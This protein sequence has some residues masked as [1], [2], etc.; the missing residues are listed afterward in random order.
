[1]RRLIPLTIVLALCAAVSCDQQ[2]V[3]PPTDGAAAVPLFAPKSN[4]HKFVGEWDFTFPV[5][6]SGG[7]ILEWH[8]WGWGQFMP[9]KSPNNVEVAVF[10]IHHLYTNSTGDTFHYLDVGPDHTY[11]KDGQ[12][13]VAITG[14]SAASGNLERTEINIG[15]VVMKLNEYWE[16]VEVIFAAGRNLG[17]LDDMACEALTS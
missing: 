12:L 5:E 14:R 11:M 13:Y 17:V 15:H 16:P 6:C 7:E 2:P 9:K 4:A 10:H 3:E 8:L 1:M